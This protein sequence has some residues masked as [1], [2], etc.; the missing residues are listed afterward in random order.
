MRRTILAASL[1]VLALGADPARAQTS[2]PGGHHPAG[3][4]EVKRAAGTGIV[5]NIDRNKGTVTIKH[6]PLPAL[7]MAGGHTMTFPVKD[8]TQLAGLKPLQKVEFDL[9]YDGKE[10]LILQIMRAQR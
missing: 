5:Q 7:Q 1:L 4:Q 3:T 9:S 10:F 6:G 8:K 2:G